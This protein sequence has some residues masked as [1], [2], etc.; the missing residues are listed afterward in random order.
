MFDIFKPM[1]LNTTE[2]YTSEY[3]KIIK[4][5]LKG[6]TYRNNLIILKL[7]FNEIN[8]SFFSGKIMSGISKTLLF[9]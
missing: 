6:S 3:L 4:G 5:V 1:S 9:S 7:Y 2:N 8:L